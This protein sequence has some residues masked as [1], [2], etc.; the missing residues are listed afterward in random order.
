MRVRGG[1]RRAAGPGR[2]LDIG[3]YGARGVPSTYSGYETFL[4]LLLPEL[5]ANG[6]RVT[7][8]CRSG[9]D[10]D[11]SDWNGV[12]RTV[13]PAI[14]G[15]NTSTLSHGLVAAVAAR[16]ARHDVVLVVNVAN[17]AFCAL[18]RYTGQP[19]VL[20][21]DGQE[22]LRGKWGTTARRIFHSSARIAKWCA[23]ANGRPSIPASCALY[24]LDPSSHTGGRCDALGTARTV[25]LL[26]PSR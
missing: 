10:F 26:A 2:S 24:P 11:A 7:I 1:K 9:E 17:A 4:T 6:D 5:A 12:H 14:P 21:V 8:Y 18:G 19:V 22:W 25:P 13:L 3:V 20:N 15:K 16:A 23:N